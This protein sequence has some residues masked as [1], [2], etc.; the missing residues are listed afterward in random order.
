MGAETWTL[1]E[2]RLI[3]TLRCYDRFVRDQRLGRL[4]NNQTYSVTQ[5][6]CLS[7]FYLH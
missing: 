3:P 1:L 5:Q 7:F 4:L 6:G 2:R